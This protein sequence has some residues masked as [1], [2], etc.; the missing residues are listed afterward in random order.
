MY[1]QTCGAQNRD[2]H[3][4]CVRCHQKL[5][6]L[7]GGVRDDN[8]QYEEGSEEN[9]FSFD[10]HLLERISILEEAVKRTAETVRQL[11]GALHKQEKNI[12]I[13]QTGLSALRELL[14]QKRF[15]GWD[16]WS[17]LWESKMDYQL[18]ALEKRERFLSIKERIAALHHG[19]KRKVF[20]QHLEDAEYAL[21][22]FDI[23]RAVAAL[24]AA[25]KLD[26]D[27]YELAYFLGETHFNEGESEQALTYFARVLE[28]KPDHYEGL[29]YSGVIYYERGDHTRAEDNLKRAVAIY[30]ESFLP[31]FS[32]GAVYAGQGNLA[33]AVLFL[34]RA[35]Q[36]DTVPQA[37]YLLGSCCYEMGKLSAA[38][39]HLQE[40]VRADPAFEE[41]HH[42]LGLAYLD[43]HWNRKALESFRQAQR[44]NPKKLQY[45]DL[46][47]YLSGHSGGSPLPGV[48]GEAEV[49]FRKGEELL[50]REKLKQAHSCYRR[51][52]ALEPENPTLLMS[53]ALL[54]L[55]LNRSHE[56][57]AVT[58]KVLDLN[59]GEMLRATAYAALIEAL[60]SQGKY[61]EGNRIGL[62]MVDEGNSNF[63][64][65]IAYYEMAYNL[66]EMEED[67][68]EALTYARR[69]VELSPDEIK[70]FPLA[71]L[72]WVHYKRKEFEKAIDFL[73]KS[74]EL[75]PSS[76]TLTHL[77]MALLASGEEDRARSVLAHARD[78]GDR[79][80][81]LQERMM[82][83]MKDSTRLLE[84][85]RRGQKR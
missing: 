42:L 72:G 32:L 30:P 16:E 34:E 17:D 61:R 51:A 85:V 20:L 79:G 83:C 60:R 4:Y 47:S 70:Q 7:S 78:L 80:E 2:D 38:L 53:Y 44:L 19:D 48:Q 74:T 40:A 56:I 43:R 6:V 25:F 82:A 23:E 75:G 49:W 39:Q 14:E 62:R 64:K 67:L 76:T 59:P 33:K 3:E 46:V 13:N 5:L 11:L 63:S 28:V 81:G 36:V 52:L 58:R 54:C 71:A 35:V 21:F 69:S 37:L 31:L 73:S 10:E 41:A 1:C 29:V 84:R 24:E 65:T 55:H 8:E 68:D 57:E 18:L 27:N 15:I 26:R 12:L 45:Q 22:A 50:A 77:G 9:N 66:A